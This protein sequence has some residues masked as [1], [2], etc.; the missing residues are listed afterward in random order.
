MIHRSTFK[1]KVLHL[2]SAVIRG[3]LRGVLTAGPAGGVRQAEA[4]HGGL[5]GFCRGGSDAL[6]C[7]WRTCGGLKG[8]PVWC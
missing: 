2:C 7:W 5:L 4:A 1:R 6:N 3:S 8:V